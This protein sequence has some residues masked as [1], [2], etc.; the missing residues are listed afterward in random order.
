M[1]L[2][3]L[4]NELSS[5]SF[6]LFLYKMTWWKKMPVSKCQNQSINW[7][8]LLYILRHFVLNNRDRN[9]GI[10][11]HFYLL[12]KRTILTAWNRQNRSIRDLESDLI[13]RNK[14]NRLLLI[15]DNYL[16]FRKW[17]NVWLPMIFLDYP[18]T[19]HFSIKKASNSSSHPEYISNQPK[20]SSVITLFISVIYYISLFHILLPE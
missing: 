8:C 11:S 9:R 1:R 20:L 2:V 16:V 7:Q 5:Y 18:R 4:F 17:A 10:H 14:Q 12:L 3:Y 19:C 13:V 15:Q 6:I